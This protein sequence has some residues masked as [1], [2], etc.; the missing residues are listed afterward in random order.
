VLALTECRLIAIVIG[1][2]GISTLAG[3]FSDSSALVLASD[4]ERYFAENGD[5]GSSFDIG[6]QP[7]GTLT[8]IYTARPTTFDATKK[9]F[10]INGYVA[11]G[12]GNARWRESPFWPKYLSYLILHAD[13][14][15]QTALVG[16][17][18]RGYG[19]V[20]ARQPMIDGARYQSPLG[21][22]KN[23][24]YDTSQFRRVP[25]AT[26]QIGDPGFQ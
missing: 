12:T 13:P 3:C 15:C 8:D 11:S 7:D 26:A 19:W 16:Y 2:L 1:A 9:S 6:F 4:V 10:V 20:F 18:R 22:L 17:L 5:V 24:G 25:Q 14:D 21:R 23:R